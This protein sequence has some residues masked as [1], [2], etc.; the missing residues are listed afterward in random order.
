MDWKGISL[1]VH[2]SGLCFEKKKEARHILARTILPF[3]RLR[4]TVIWTESHGWLRRCTMEIQTKGN[5]YESMVQ[6]NCN[7]YENMVLSNTGK[8]LEAESTCTL[9]QKPSP[10]KTIDVLQHQIP[11]FIQPT[12]NF[13][14]RVLFVSI[15][16]LLSSLTAVILAGIALSRSKESNVVMAPTKQSALGASNPGK[17]R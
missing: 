15:M 6:A 4:S 10:A 13:P 11:G 14:K 12:S 3:V 16:A 7:V 8:Q 9:E 17:E 1:K 5:D 2:L